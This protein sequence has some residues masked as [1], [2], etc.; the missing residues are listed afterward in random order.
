MADVKTIIENMHV[1]ALLGRRN[2]V[3]HFGSAKV[4]TEVQTE[5]A[6]PRDLGVLTDRRYVDQV[7]FNPIIFVFS[8]AILWFCET[9]S[10]YALQ[11][12]LL[13]SHEHFFAQFT[14]ELLNVHTRIC[15][16]CCVFNTF[17]C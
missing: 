4:R 16:D 7:L 2:P 3:L 14:Y 12:V 6:T 9:L 8:G 10:R 15:L 17:H 11:L 1:P 13:C 5:V